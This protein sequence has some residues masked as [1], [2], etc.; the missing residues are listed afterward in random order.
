LSIIT[1]MKWVD[2]ESRSMIIQIESNLRAVM[3]KPPIK[4][5]LMSILSGCNN[6]PGFM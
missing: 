6:P 3:G 5:I 4:S 2:L 1:G